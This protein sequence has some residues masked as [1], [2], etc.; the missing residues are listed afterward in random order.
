MEDAEHSPKQTKTSSKKRKSVKSVA[1]AD[2]IP[3]EQPKS[4]SK[5][6][7]RGKKRKA[8]DVESSKEDLG[9]SADDEPKPATNKRK[10]NRKASKIAADNPE[11]GEADN[12][13][14]KDN[15]TAPRRSK[16]RTSSRKKFD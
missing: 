13:G 12:G 7:A 10:A 4:E 3:D 9:E 16:R 5:S 6:S 2:N 14:G 8:T 15:E 1:D 11:Q